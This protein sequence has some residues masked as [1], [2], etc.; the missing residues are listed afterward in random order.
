MTADGGG[1]TSVGGLGSLDEAT[2]VACPEAVTLSGSMDDPA[3]SRFE[4]EEEVEVDVCGGG[5]IEEVDGDVLVLVLALVEVGAVDD[6]IVLV[7]AGAALVAAPEVAG[8]PGLVEDCGT[9]CEDG[10]GILLA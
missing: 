9:I 3:G 7:C 5:P 10:D 4:V 8:W 1:A 6:T 2:T